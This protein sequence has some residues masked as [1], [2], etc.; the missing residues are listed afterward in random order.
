MKTAFRILLLTLALT[1]AASSGRTCAESVRFDADWPEFMACHDLVWERLPEN[2]FEGAFV[3]NGLLGTIVFRDSIRKNSLCFEIGR[4]D[5]YDHREGAPVHQEGGRLPIGQ[6]LLTPVGKITGAKLR[7]DLWNAE[8][9]GEIVTDAGEIKWRCF[10]PSG[11]EVI[12][13]ELTTTAGERGTEFS[14][15]AMQ[16]DSPRLTVLP[17]EKNNGSW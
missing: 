9:R 8:T 1:F 15:R 5:I 17:K 10:V 14:F 6:A 11:G 3:G 4:T 16:G 12:V 7:T 2:Y 13:L